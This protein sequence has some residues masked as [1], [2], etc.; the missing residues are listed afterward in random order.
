LT[1]FFSYGKTLKR[2]GA[3]S[4]TKLEAKERVGK[5]IILAIE[6]IE[7]YNLKAGDHFNKAIPHPRASKIKYNPAEPI[8]WI[9]V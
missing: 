6:K 4:N 1:Q 5:A 8:D 3:F 2:E 9:L 7:Q